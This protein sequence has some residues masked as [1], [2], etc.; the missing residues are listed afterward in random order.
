[1]PKNNKQTKIS[2]LFH[3][4]LKNLIFERSSSISHALQ[5]IDEL[6]SKLNRRL[7]ILLFLGIFQFLLLVYLIS[8]SI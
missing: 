8:K 6:N 5:L 3:N 7:V 1:M 2:K 4:E